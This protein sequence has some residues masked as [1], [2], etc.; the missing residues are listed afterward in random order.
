MKN[1]G[2]FST[3]FIEDVREE[4]ELDDQARGRM[5]TLAQTWS[6]SQRDTADDLW[7]TFMKQALGYLKFVPANAPSSPGVYPL[8]EDWGFENCIALLFLVK[9]GADIDD[10]AVGRFWPAKL[11]VELKRRKLNWGI[12]TDGSVWRLYS[13][14]SSRPFEDY[15]EL[16]LAEALADDDEAEYGLFERFFHK[17]SFIPEEADEDHEQ[18]EQDEAAG[19]YKC[20]LDADQEASEGVL[21][22]WVKQPLL[23]QVDEILRYLCNGFI[24]DTPRKGEEYTE[25]ERKQIFESAV[26][27]MYR[28][29]FLFYAE[30]RRLLPSEADKAEIYEKHSIHALCAEARKFRWGQRKDTDGYDLWKHFKG[31]IN[32]VNDGD[33]EYGIMGYNGGL[34][35]DEEEVFLGRHKLRND[36]FARPL[37]L[38][39]Y[40]EPFNNDPD[41]EYEIPY[42]DLEVRHL[43]ELYE[44]IL[45][46]TV[47]LADADRIRRRTKKGVQLPAHQERC[48]VSPGVGD[49]EGE[50][51]LAHP[52]GRCLLRRVSPGAQA[53]RVVLHARIAG[54]L[55]ERQSDHR[56]PAGEVRGRLQAALRPVPRPGR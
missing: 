52:Q 13:V 36:F 31:L 15:V 16:P 8:Y 30:A 38:L 47:M 41:D 17:D 11:I 23:D 7:G 42:E 51:R 40:V 55:P 56:T 37:Y 25:E 44:N 33:P 12:L 6:T 19:V 9:P 26:K 3:L 29:L 1:N 53:D 48:A 10:A 35:D 5:A 43:G 28:C 50:E 32:A 21:D 34:F 14:K 49:D 24:A 46:Y 18:A 2:L 39:A 4:I 45:E 20:R 54:P 27:L 22:E